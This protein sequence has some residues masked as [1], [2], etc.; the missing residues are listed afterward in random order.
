MADRYESANADSLSLFASEGD[1]DAARVSAVVPST[2]T[3]AEMLSGFTPELKNR[4]LTGTQSIVVLVESRS[5]ADDSLSVFAPEGRVG[6]VESAALAHPIVD[7]LGAFAAEGSAHPVDAAPRTNTIP[8]LTL[9]GYACTQPSPAARSRVASWGMRSAAAF[10]IGALGTLGV[11]RRLE[12]PGSLPPLEHRPIAVQSAALLIAVPEFKRS[13][14]DLEKPDPVSPIA[15]ERDR[16]MGSARATSPPTIT[17]DRPPD[18]AINHPPPLDGAVVGSASVAAT[19]GAD[20]PIPAAAVAPASMTILP[21]SDESAVRRTVE[22]YAHAYQD[23]D[24]DAAASVWP[25]VDRRTLSR[26]FAALKSQDLAFDACDIT[27]DAAR[28]IASCRGTLQIVR[29]VG[30]PAPIRAEQQWVFR[31]RRLSGDWKIDDVS[32]VQMTAATRGDDG[33]E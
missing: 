31:M 16:P 3:A 20:A 19:R 21:A 8:S 2:V 7:P 13:A 29:R 5:G 14:V 11:L 25:S 26:A 22:R 9:A 1:A 17:A 27:V 23:L 12:H 32:A 24:V 6:C 4:A 30:S 18:R 33:S 15:V 28:A 10:L